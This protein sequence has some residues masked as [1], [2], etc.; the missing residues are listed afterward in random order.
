MKPIFNTDLFKNYD[1]TL[2][3][4]KYVEIM[5]NCEVF[6]SLVDKIM[7]NYEIKIHSFTIKRILSFY[8]FP[9]NY[10]NLKHGSLYANGIQKHSLMYLANKGII[11]A[12]SKDYDT[13]YV[14]SK[15]IEAL[16][17]REVNLSVI[18]D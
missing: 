12:V 11:K 16:I 15:E 8:L 6:N 9:Q 10:N 3:Y 13:Y 17:K 18:L 2:D 5:D 4:K 14:F 7:S 1:Q